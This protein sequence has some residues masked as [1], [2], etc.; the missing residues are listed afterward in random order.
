VLIQNDLKTT[1]FWISEKMEVVGQNLHKIG[2]FAHALLKL[3]IL[4]KAY[5]Y[6]LNL[7]L[8]NHAVLRSTSREVFAW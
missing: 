7:T 3:T 8:N 5:N 4:E 1:I 2:V 6:L